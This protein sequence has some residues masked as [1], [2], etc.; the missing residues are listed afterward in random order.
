MHVKSLDTST[1]RLIDLNPVVTK[2]FFIDILFRNTH[3]GEIG[4]DDILIDIE[5]KY[6]HFRLINKNNIVTTSLARASTT[7][8]ACW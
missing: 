1:S 4:R 3:Q 6:R 5:T 8:S 7:G 2:F